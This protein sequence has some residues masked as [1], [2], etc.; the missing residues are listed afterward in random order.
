M[1]S[2]RIPTLFFVLVTMLIVLWLPANHL[3]AE[4]DVAVVEATYVVNSVADPGDGTCNTIECTLREAIEAAN[5]SSGLDLIAFNIPGEGPHTIRPMTPLPPITD[6]AIIDGYTQPGASQNTNP[7]GQGLNTVLMIELEGSLTSADGLVFPP[8]PMAGNRE[9]RGL[10]I[11]RFTGAGINVQMSNDDIVIAGNYIGTDVTG[12]VALGNAVGIQ[13]GNYAWKPQIGGLLA[14]DRNLI[15]GNDDGIY[16]RFTALDPGNE[17]TILGNLIG[18]DASGT[19]PIPNGI[20]VN[21]DFWASGNVIGGDDP[22]AANVIAGNSG[23]GI[24]IWE[25]KNNEIVNNLIGTDVTGQLA[26]P[27]GGNGIQVGDFFGFVTVDNEIRHNVIA[28]NVGAGVYVNHYVELPPIDVYGNFISENR[29]FSNGGL[30]IDLT[31]I[32]VNPNDSGDG[33]VGANDLQNYPEVTLAAS[34]GSGIRIQGTLSSVPDSEFH[35]EFYANRSCDESGYG[36]GEEYLGSGD[37]TTGSDGVAEFEVTVPPDVAI[38]QYISATATNAAG[39]TSEFSECRWFGTVTSVELVSFT[40]SADP[41]GLVTLEWETAAE[42]DN[43]G[44]NLYRRVTDSDPDTNLLVNPELIAS[45]SSAGSGARYAFTDAP[46]L[47]DWTYSLASVTTD[48]FEEIED[49]VDVVVQVPTSA[50]LTQFEANGT[51]RIIAL[52]LWLRSAGLC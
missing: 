33:D 36:E 18:T 48:G 27:N 29:I 52:R 4:K 1:S 34:T 32:G 13:L 41:A 25:A 45:Q 30:G 39:S 16:L 17:A 3:R 44:F 10:A 46:G 24:R 50:E 20:G 15:S 40:A 37:V 42:I 6:P 22:Q 43:A 14:A 7:T 38:G 47:G 19:I 5:A 8:P 35:L 12:E 28:N 26:L 2:K 9:V 21:A 11:N 51:D 31:P 23:H 49:S